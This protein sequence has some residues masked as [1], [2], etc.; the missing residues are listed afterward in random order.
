MAR[1]R[2]VSR[3]AVTLNAPEGQPDAHEVQ[4]GDAVKIQGQITSED[5][6]AIVVGSG[7]S[8]RAYSKAMWRNAD[9]STEGSSEGT[10]KK[11]TQKNS[12]TQNGKENK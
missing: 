9:E 6:D 12:G 5:E 2:N 1:I 11:S 10:V 7:P 4:P 8:A 3:R